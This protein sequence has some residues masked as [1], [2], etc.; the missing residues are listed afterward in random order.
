[1]VEI[2][3]TR[4]GNTMGKL[5][6][7]VII[8]M[9]LGLYSNISHG[10]GW[11]TAED[12]KQRALKIVGPEKAEGNCAK[13]H[14]VETDA[15]KQTTHFST[16]KE[17]HRSEKAK[18]ILT[19]MGEK[20]MKRSTQCRQCHY[21]STVKKESVRATYGVSCESCHGAGK[22]WLAIHVKKGGA[23]DGADLKWGEAKLETPQ[24][25]EARLSKSQ[26]A[27]M[28]NSD[29]I[30]DIAKNCF[31]CHT[32]PNE[33]VVNLG[34]HPAGSGDFELLSWS[35][36]EILHNFASAEGTDKSGQNLPAS[37]NKKRR[38]FITGKLVDLET[39]LYNISQ[40]GDQAGKYYLAM[41][42]RANKVKAE[43]IEITSGANL[44]EL[45]ALVSGLAEFSADNAKGISEQLST[46]TVTFLKSHDGSQLSG[47]DGFLPTENKGSPF[48]ATPSAE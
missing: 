5:F 27:G 43:L 30:Y 42:E 40:S 32:V 25:R 13:C 16:F 21:T 44:N 17:A 18:E 34:D 15:W 22:D 35:Q 11:L 20:S 39:T 29:M 26:A 4:S 45:N 1:M 6:S 8:A 33:Q 10:Y 41:I 23:E 31:G 38:L 12:E 48:V 28:I 14:S 9:T 36:G 47:L 7:L 2:M 37:L 3:K 24:E 46:T 19:A